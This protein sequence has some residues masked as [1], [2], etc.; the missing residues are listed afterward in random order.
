MVSSPASS[1]KRR[2][3]AIIPSTS[4]IVVR[5]ERIFSSS[6]LVCA[7]TA[8]APR[9]ARGRPLRARS[10]RR[11]A[12]EPGR[13]R[14]MRYRRPARSSPRAR[15]ARGR[16]SVVVSICSR[17]SASASRG[18]SE[19][20]TRTEPPTRAVSCSS[21]DSTTSS[22]RLM[23]STWSTVCA[24]SASTWLEIEHRPPV[25]GERA[26][27]VAQPAHALRV[28]PVGRLVEDQQLRVAEQRRREP[29]PLP[30]PERV[31]L[32]AALRRSRRARPAA[33]PRRRASRAA[34]RPGSSVRRW[35][36]PERPGWK[37]V[38]SSTAPT[39]SAGRSS[40]A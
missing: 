2:I 3:S 24:T 29:E 12:R 26:Q 6:A 18:S 20:R 19:L 34:R 36:R 35:S 22:P 17:R 33:A 27:E 5:V 25:G 38:A 15:A 11:R 13:R 7:I 10:P 30:H 32:D 1:A 21:E 14:R 28:E 9:S 37:S 39:R 8:A 16:C 4:P 23:I 40:S 31:A